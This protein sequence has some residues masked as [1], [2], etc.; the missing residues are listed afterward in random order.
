MIK[1]VENIMVNGS[2]EDPE[3]RGVMSLAIGEFHPLQ[4]NANQFK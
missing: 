1:S 4:K 2:V 3:M